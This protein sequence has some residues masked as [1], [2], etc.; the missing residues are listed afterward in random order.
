MTLLFADSFSHYSAAQGSQK[1]TSNTGSFT[2]SSGNG[3]YIGDSL[4]G[5]VVATKTFDVQE[6]LIC[7]IAARRVSDPGT[8]TN[9]FLEIEDEGGFLVATL[10]LSTGTDRK[11]YLEIMGV[12]YRS[13]ELNGSY[14]DWQYLEI[15]LTTINKDIYFE[16]RLNEKLMHSG[17]LSGVG[18]ERL[19]G[20]TVKPN[21]GSFAMELDDL[22]VCSGEGTENND[23]LGDIQ[24]EALFPNAVGTDTDWSLTGAASNHVAT[25]DNPADGDTS[26]VSSTTLA[27]KDVY[28]F[29]NLSL[30]SGTVLGTQMVSYSR[31]EESGN[32]SMQ[33]VVS[34]NATESNSSD[35]KIDETTYKMYINATE[36]DPDTAV[37]WTVSGINAAQFGQEISL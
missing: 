29:D 35:F 19:A 23:F 9:A 18:A 15:K 26:Y 8:G 30:A 28:N 4:R 32:R 12:Q 31:K 7:G 21:N 27:E 6:T 14:A 13:P 10:N 33:L 17:T 20:I 3:R 11:Y 24:V 37:A 36:T 2:I 16:W 5:S 22:Y 34:S 1:Y 25:Q